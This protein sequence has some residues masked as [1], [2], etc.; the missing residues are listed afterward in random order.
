MRSI[1]PVT[2]LTLAATALLTSVAGS[3]QTTTSAEAARKATAHAKAFIYS[4]EQ[5]HGSGMAGSVVLKPVGNK[6]QVTVMMS[7]PMRGNPAISLHPGTDCVD[8]RNATAADVALAPMNA[9]GANAP[10]SQTLINLP[11]EQ[12]KNRNYVVDV[13][14]A[15][16]RARVAQACARLNR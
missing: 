2:A 1:V 11:I 12:L 10:T 16:E 8:N 15:T 14:N 9:A 3:A 4:L 7:S 6:T 13:R 5:R